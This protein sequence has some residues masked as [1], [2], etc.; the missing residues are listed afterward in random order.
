MGSQAL[1][2]YVSVE[3]GVAWD[4]TLLRGQQNY[5][6]EAGSSNAEECT[7]GSPEEAETPA[8]TAL[9]QPLT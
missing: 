3:A 2:I 8:G 9:C 6:H 5:N 7:R 4:Q 1:G